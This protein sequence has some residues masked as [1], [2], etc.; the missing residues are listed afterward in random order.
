MLFRIN[1]SS[2]VPIYVQLMEQVK[3]AI[4][5]GALQA[6][7]QLPGIRPLSEEMVMN[8]NTVA[9]AYRELAHEGVI[10]LRHGAGAFVSPNARADRVADK[11]RAAQPLVA[12]TVDKL[13]ARGL[14]EEEIRRLFEAELAA[15]RKGG[16]RA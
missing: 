2:G 12:G 3:H 4:E 6:G 9:K 1:P 13:R 14:S 10:E 8:P 7:D 15:P 11:L 5:T 16:R